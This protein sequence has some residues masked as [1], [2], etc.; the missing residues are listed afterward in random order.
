MNDPKH[1]RLVITVPQ[2][3]AA[4]TAAAL[5]AYCVAVSAFELDPGGDWIIEAIATTLPDPEA[6]TTSLALVEAVSGVSVP[7]PTVESLPDIDWL[8]ENRK[9]SFLSAPSGSSFAPVIQMPCHP[10]VPLY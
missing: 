4:M 2:A 3:A 7:L 6:L 5:E 9:A 10:Q 1:I 8:A